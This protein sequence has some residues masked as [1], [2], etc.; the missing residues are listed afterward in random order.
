M[1][2]DAFRRIYKNVSLGKNVTM[3][4]FVIIGLPPASRDDGE[5][6]T[7]IGD[8]AVIHSHTVIYAGNVIG[9]NFFTGHA[10]MIRECNLIGNEV[11]IGTHSVIEH[12]LKIENKVRIHSQTF[13]PEYSILEEGCWIGPKVT[14]TNARHPL[15]PQV[16]ECLKGP[17][18]K[19]GAKIGANATLLP[20]ITVGENAVVGAGAV[21]T[22]D[23]P[24]GAVVIGNPARIIKD[25]GE[26]SCRSG[27]REKPYQERMS[28]VRR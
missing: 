25:I 28:C 21:V 1:A 7:A 2:K 11:S 5:L 19:R 14:F 23:V 17:I 10:V 12:H 18:I 15:C 20:G 4:D 13:I 26:L 3:G 16:K 8:N 27:L 9:D 22:N 24:P 6:K